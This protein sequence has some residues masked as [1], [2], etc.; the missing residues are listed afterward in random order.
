MRYLMTRQT[1]NDLKEWAMS[2]TKAPSD[3][4]GAV[5]IRNNLG[6]VLV[7]RRHDHVPA[8]AGM[9]QFPGGSVDEGETFIDGAIRELREETNL[10]VEPIALTSLGTWNGEKLGVPYVVEVFLL[11]SEWNMWPQQMEPDKAGPW[12]WKSY[13]E[14]MSEQCIPGLLGA[15]SLAQSF[16]DLPFGYVRRQHLTRSLM[17]IDEALRRAAQLPP[18]LGITD[19]L[20]GARNHLITAQRISR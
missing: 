17:H 3:R 10:S 14:L 5:L 1:Y 19:L 13:G 11:D 16:A 6:H 20:H 7:S 9:W 18:V 15:A 12:V 2:Q 4:G 8:F